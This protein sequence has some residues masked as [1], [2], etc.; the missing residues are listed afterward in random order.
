MLVLLAGIL[1]GCSGWGGEPDPRPK[2]LF[3][4]ADD[5]GY[6]DI[7]SCGG[8]DRLSRQKKNGRAHHRGPGRSRFVS[9]LGL[10]SVGC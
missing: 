3:I 7:G 10:L 9:G 5:L 8:W 6:S 1:A 4:T 2:I